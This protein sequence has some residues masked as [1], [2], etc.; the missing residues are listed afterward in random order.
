MTPG[1]PIGGAETFLINLINKFRTK[2]NPIVVSLGA[3]NDSLKRLH[4]EI[5][6]IELKRKWRYDLSI[7]AKLKSIIKKN[8]IDCAFVISFFPFFF[9]R[10][11]VTHNKPIKLFLSLHSTKPRSIKEYIQGLVYA[12]LLNGE[13]K[14]ITVCKNQ[15]KYLSKIYKISLTQFDTIY[16]GVDTNNFTLP[17]SNFDRKQFRESLQI[18]EDAFVIIQ[19]AAFRKEKRHEDSLKALKIIHTDYNLKPYLLFV[20]GG[21]VDI[22]KKI[23]RLTQKYNLS[24]YVKFC[25]K[26]DDVCP[27]YWISNLFTLSSLSEAFSVAAIEAMACGLPCVLTNVGGA[28]EMIYEGMNGYLVAPQKPNYLADAWMKILNNKEIFNSK[29]IRQTIIERF[30]LE[31]SLSKYAKLL[32]VE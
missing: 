23:K 30:S 3:G 11:A 29:N 22:E 1:F 5:N 21:N 4:P 10:Y 6:V 7:I 26:Q 17:P 14:L 9:L 19:V 31:A 15:A 13:E 24:E 8:D 28:N 20:G 12:R 27:Y 16:N 32:G 2:I 18:P 25:G